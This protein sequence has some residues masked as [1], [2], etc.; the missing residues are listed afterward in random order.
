MVPL[1]CGANRQVAEKNLHPE[2]LRIINRSAP[3]FIPFRI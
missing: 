1:V 3:K 2:T